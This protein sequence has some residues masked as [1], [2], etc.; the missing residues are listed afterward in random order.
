MTSPTII[1][2]NNSNEYYFEEGCYILELSNSEQD[3][4]VS[5]A[6]ARVAPKTETK[7]HKLKQTIERYIILEGIGEVVV[8][9]LPPAQVVKNDI[10]IIPE[11]CAQKIA[12]TGNEDL[13]FLVIC[14]PRFT[15]DNYV[16]CN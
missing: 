3:S 7:L 10:V 15:I 12:N 13:I 14:T 1:H 8:G 9:D 5:I 2:S 4:G 6:K 11:N 16:E